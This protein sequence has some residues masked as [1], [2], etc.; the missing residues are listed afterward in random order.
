MSPVSALGHMARAQIAM[1]TPAAWG[2]RVITNMTAIEADDINLSLDMGTLKSRV[3]HNKLGP[4]A[5]YQMGMKAVGSLGAEWRYEG[6]LK[7]LASMMGK[8]GTFVLTNTAV[9]TAT[10]TIGKTAQGSLPSLSLELDEGG[11]YASGGDC[12]LGL[13]ILIPRVKFSINAGVGED[14]ILRIEAD[15]LGKDKQYPTS[16]QFTAGVQA[17]AQ[18]PIFFSDSLDASY[19]GNESAATANVTGFDI[20]IIKPLKERYF[21]VPAS[22]NMA[23]PLW[24]DQVSVIWTIRKEFVSTSPFDASRAFTD[25]PL[26]FKFQSATSIPSSSPDTKYSLEFSSPKAKLMPVQDPRVNEFGVLEQ[27]LTFEAYE[28]ST[29]GCLKVAAAQSKV[30]ESSAGA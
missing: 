17:A 22:K 19:L 25:V 11:I 10:Y 29:D 28:D 26:R 14:A 12:A 24:D 6:M 13:G 27:T 5:I 23:Q 15:L 21:I 30:S 1:E 2:T 18:L 9:Q 3:F 4:R 7:L 8:L 16:A 20:E